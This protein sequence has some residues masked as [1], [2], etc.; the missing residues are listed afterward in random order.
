[1]S[2]RKTLSRVTVASLA[3]VALAAPAA[4]AMPV[5]PAG[6]RQADV[7]VNPVTKESVHQRGEPAVERSR[8]SVPNPRSVPPWWA[9]WAGHH[10]GAQTAGGSVDDGGDDVPVAL[11]VIGGALVLAGGTAAVAAFRP[12]TR[13]A[14]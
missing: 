11:L 14:L 8:L 3:A 6:T 5:D 10:A 7:S 2:H 9:E 1:M 4:T 12:R 13:T